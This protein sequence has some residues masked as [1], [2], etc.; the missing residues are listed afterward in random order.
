MTDE[1]KTTTTDTPENDTTDKSKKH[2]TVL[3]E[4]GELGDS[5]SKLAGRAVESLKDT[6]DQS[7][8]SRSNV[9]TIRVTDEANKKLNMLVDAGIFKSRSESASFLIDEG[10]KHQEKLFNKIAERLA[11]IEKLRDELKDIINEEMKTP[12]ETKTTE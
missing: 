4:L 8:I 10:I 2:K 11:T 5:V 6:I 9:L 7:L 12:D 1:K 3:K